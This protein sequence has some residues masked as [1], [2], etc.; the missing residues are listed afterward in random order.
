M[1]N[2]TELNKKTYMISIILGQIMAQ[3]NMSKIPS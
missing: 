1:K 3:N 2:D